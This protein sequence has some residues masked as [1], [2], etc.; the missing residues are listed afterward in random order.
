VGL[1]ENDKNL[2]KLVIEFGE[3]PLGVRLTLRPLAF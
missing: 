3:A 2:E 1:I